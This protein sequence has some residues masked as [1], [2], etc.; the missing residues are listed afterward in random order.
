M[1]TPRPPVCRLLKTK[2]TIGVVVDGAVVPWE[3]GDDPTAAYWCIATTAP[4]GPDDALAHPHA[5][6]SGRACFRE[7]H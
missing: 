5:C 7:R 3:S 6:L 1:E 2:K 4:V